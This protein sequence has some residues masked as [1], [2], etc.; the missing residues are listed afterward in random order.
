VSAAATAW[1]WTLD[2]PPRDKFVLVALAD[3]HNQ[4]EDAA[5]MKQE[6]IA[7]RT[8]YTR[9]TVNAAL[10][11]LE[12]EH[13]L[14]TSRG[15][16]YSDGR[17]ASKIYRLHMAADHVK[18][19]DTDAHR[20]NAVD[21]DHVKETDTDRVKEID[22]KNLK[23]RTEN[24]ELKKGS[25]KKKEP[26]EIKQPGKTAPP[27]VDPSVWERFR[28]HRSQLR[29]P[30][31]AEAVRLIARRL[32]EHPADANEMLE[33]S[34]ANGWTGVFPLRRN[35]KGALTPEESATQDATELYHY[36]RARRDAMREGGS[37]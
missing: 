36:L 35:G 30:L 22:N 18:E 34:I 29:R 4:D 2:L 10:A 32:A 21:T 15:R 8:G 14:I 37:E 11:A 26:A 23:H 17:N 20:V 7:K 24:I 12:H 31:T 1:A 28:K 27:H 5:W 9:Q 3:H 16:K 25:E 19:I 13:G 6:T 33:N